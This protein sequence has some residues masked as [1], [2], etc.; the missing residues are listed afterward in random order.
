MQNFF[1]TVVMNYLL[2]NGDAH[3]KNFGLLFSDDFSEI[4]FSPA[5]DVVNTLVYIH[6]DKPALTLNGK[7]IWWSKNRLLKFGQ[8]HCFL[9]KTQSEVCYN[10]C[11]DALKLSINDLEN[12]IQ[13]NKHFKQI[14][15]KMLDCW[16]LSLEEKDMKELD[17]ELI[18][19]WK[20]Y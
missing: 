5:Y 13:D 2:K 14:G 19:S 4:K 17:N 3:L 1:K 9:S 6:K 15:L 12:Y 8:K 20:A 16:K 11:F 7:K 10:D 18:R